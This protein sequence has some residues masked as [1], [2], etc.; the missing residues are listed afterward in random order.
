MYQLVKKYISQGNL[1]S[2]STRYILEFFR[3]EKKSKKMKE[4]KLKDNPLYV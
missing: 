2:Q 1:L 4:L 3:N